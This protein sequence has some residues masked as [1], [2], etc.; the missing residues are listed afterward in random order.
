MTRKELIEFGQK[1]NSKGRT[2]TEIYN[3]LSI[4]VS[5]KQELSEILEHVFENEKPTT[6][7][8]PERVKVLL[9]ANKLKLNFEYSMKSLFRISGLVLVIGF[10]TYGLSRE[11]VN[12]NEIFGWMTILQGIV[13]TLLFALVKYK[14]LLNLLL[15]AV[16][17][18]FAIWLVE[19]LLWGIP[20]DLLEAYNHVR[21]SVPPSFKLKT[22]TGAAR[23]IGYI[24]PFLYVGMKL[25]LG[26][27]I[28][29]SFRNYQKF[30]ALTQDLKEDLKDF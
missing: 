20:N 1:L 2:P 13:M 8:S 27:F 9:K 22:N 30:E 3:A 15:P 19:L 11:E 14:G 4:K 17:T 21:M 5:S 28:F 24:F 12:Q 10:I 18:Y 6:K 23:F 26:W 25:L 7:K 16:V 29:T